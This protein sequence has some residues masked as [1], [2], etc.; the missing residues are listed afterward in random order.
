MKKGGG[1]GRRLGLILAIILALLAIVP[2]IG[3]AEGPVKIEVDKQQ[4]SNLLEQPVLAPAPEVAPEGPRQVEMTPPAQESTRSGWSALWSKLKEGTPKFLDQALKWTT[5]SNWAE[6]S[7]PGGLTGA[8]KKMGSNLLNSTLEL[9]TGAGIEKWKNVKSWTWKDWVWVGAMTALTFV[10]LGKVAGAG[11]RV[12]SRVGG[13]MVSR[14]AAK[15]TPKVGG[16]LLGKVGN[17]T[18]RMVRRL[19]GGTAFAQ[20]VGVAIDSVMQS[21]RINKLTTYVSTLTKR[22]KVWNQEKGLRWVRNVARPDTRNPYIKRFIDSRPRLKSLVT[23]PRR[24]LAEIPVVK[25]MA[26]TRVGRYT[27]DAKTQVWHLRDTLVKLN[28]SGMIWS[29]LENIAKS[30]VTRNAKLM[31][32]GSTGLLR[33]VGYAKREFWRGIRDTAAMMRNREAA[34]TFLSWGRTGGTWL[35]ERTNGV[36]HH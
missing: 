7:K 26:S 19:P 36:L 6:W 20:R 34:R 32:K 16:S 10:P 2:G 11:L 9:A 33:Q 15:L 27:G 31:Q 12:A 23:W 17:L 29:G 18:A 28:P 24:K 4:G 22:V 14:I 35:H 8:L 25:R 13:P 3:G 30:G 5:G 21:S 1:G